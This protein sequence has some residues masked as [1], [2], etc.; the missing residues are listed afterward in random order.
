MTSVLL[1]CVHRPV[2]V[3][4]VEPHSTACGL[5]FL[6]TYT[7][8]LLCPMWLLGM[9]RSHLTPAVLPSR[10][11]A[12]ALPSILVVVFFFFLVTGSVLVTV[13]VSTA[14]ERTMFSRLP[15]F[16]SFL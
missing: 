5:P 3:Q 2:G 15:I 4:L 12:G 1:V 14:L 6:S 10:A 7:R 11:R 8:N 16:S 13:T 9:M